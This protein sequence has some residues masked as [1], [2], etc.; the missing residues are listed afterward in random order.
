MAQIQSRRLKFEQFNVDSGV[1]AGYAFTATTAW[2]LVSGAD[3]N[4]TERSFMI[5]LGDGD[6]NDDTAHDTA[7][8]GSLYHDYTN[9]KWYIKTATSTWTVFGSAT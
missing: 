8:N 5:L 4:G 2:G 6:P 1:E 3:Q 9:L 7:P